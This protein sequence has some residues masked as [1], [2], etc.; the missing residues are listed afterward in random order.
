MAI[1][2]TITQDKYLVCFEKHS[3]GFNKPNKTTVT[4]KNHK[5]YY[6]GAMIKAHRFLKQFNRVTEIEYNGDVLYNVLMEKHD[7]LKV[8]NLTFETLDPKNFIA[9]LYTSNYDDEY[10]NKIIVVINNSIMQ[11]DHRL[12]KSIINR[13]IND[14][15]LS[16][17]F[18][19]PDYEDEE[20][21]DEDEGQDLDEDLDEDLD[22]EHDQEYDQ[23]REDLEEDSEQANAKIDTDVTENT[24]YTPA[25]NLKVK[26]NFDNMN[27]QSKMEKYLKTY[28][29]K[30]KTDEIV[31]KKDFLNGKREE[32]E[33]KEEGE[34]KEKIV[35]RAKK[36]LEL[37]KNN[38]T[39]KPK[40][41]K[42][43][44]PLKKNTTYKRGF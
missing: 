44:Q 41:Y 5:V 11:K 1:T 35:E 24:Y 38:V 19:E 3:L 31:K 16:T 26:I 2:K 4:S 18:E 42:R 34:K 22:Q 29:T 21:E 12:Y 40:T 43:V 14:T 6:K 23:D 8:N 33:E 9:K 39:D 17:C 15:T 36:M 20:D 7:K 30:D 28:Q 13:I 27:L 10:K 37:K 32:K 25:V